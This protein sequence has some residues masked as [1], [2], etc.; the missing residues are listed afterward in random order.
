MQ[1]Y[2]NPRK[3]TKNVEK[4]I[5]SLVS[6]PSSGKLKA[7]WS[8]V[9]AKGKGLGRKIAEIEGEKILESEH[10]VVMVGEVIVG[11]VMVGKVMVGEVIMIR[12]MLLRKE[13]P[14]SC[15]MRSLMY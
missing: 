1:V 11:E 8:A 7:G 9:K 3:K 5:T 10:I 6:S 14:P 13:A 12:M 2:L 15:L 4:R